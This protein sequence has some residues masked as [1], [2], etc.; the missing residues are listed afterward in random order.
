MAGIRGLQDINLNPWLIGMAVSLQ[1]NPLV[2]P[3]SAAGPAGGCGGHESAHRSCRLK[4]FC[5]SFLESQAQGHLTGHLSLITLES[6]LQ[7]STLTRGQRGE[8]MVRKLLL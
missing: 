2:L 3:L 5:C 8:Q 7:M 1:P 4:G 6:Q